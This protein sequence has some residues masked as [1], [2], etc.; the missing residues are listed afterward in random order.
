MSDHDIPHGGFLVPT[1]VDLDASI[2]ILCYIDSEVGT[3]ADGWSLYCPACRTAVTPVLA[4]TEG[5]QDLDGLPDH[6]ADAFFRA[7]LRLSS[8]HAAAQ[9]LQPQT[10]SLDGVRR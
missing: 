8:E 6:L 4:G 7:E 1:K 5:V 9:S 2:L 10:V 3:R